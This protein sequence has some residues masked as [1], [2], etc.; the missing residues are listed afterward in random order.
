MLDFS[1]AQ[2]LG[3]AP[4]VGHPFAC[5]ERLSWTHFDYDGQSTRTGTIWA[6]G[7]TINGKCT[8]WVIPDVRRDD[9]AHAVLLRIWRSG[10]RR[11]DA[12]GGKAVVRPGGGDLRRLSSRI[13]QDALKAALDSGANQMRAQIDAGK[14]Y[15][16]AMK[17]AA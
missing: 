12:E 6:N 7:P 1:I 11:G 10:K 17:V 3:T 16:E 4:P 9:E 5:G 8:L 2:E 13:Y 14:A 15:A